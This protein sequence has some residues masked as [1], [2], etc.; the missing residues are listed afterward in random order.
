MEQNK[1]QVSALPNRLPTAVSDRLVYCQRTVTNGYTYIVFKLDGTLDVDR[2][3]R[4]VRLLVDAEPVLGSRF[5][6]GRFSPYW[7]RRDDL[8]DVEWVSVIEGTLVETMLDELADDRRDP[9]VDPVF[10]VLLFRG[11]TDQLTIEICNV[12]SDGS[13]GM[14]LFQRIGAI[15]EALAAHPDHVPKIGRFRE[16]GYGVVCRAMGWKGRWTILKNGVRTALRLNRAG[17]WK[18]EVPEEGPERTFRYTVVLEPDRVRRLSRYGRKHGASV[19]ILVLTAAYRALK[20][21][22]CPDETDPLPIMMPVSL[23][24]YFPGEFDD[25]PTHFVGA[26]FLL[27]QGGADV[28]FESTLE[29]FR[30]QFKAQR[31]TFLGMV[32][33]ALIVESLPPLNALFHCIPYSLIKSMVR[34]RTGRTRNS[35]GP[36]LMSFSC[37]DLPANSVRLG[38]HRVESV[39]VG[40]NVPRIAGVAGFGVMRIGDRLSITTMGFE[41]CLSP[42]RLKSVVDSLVEDL[43]GAESQETERVRGRGLEKEGGKECVPQREAA[44]PNGNGGKRKMNVEEKVREIILG[45]VD[46]SEDEIKA[47]SKLRSD[48]G[49]T[50]VEIVEVVAA[51]ENEFDIDI[52]DEEVQEIRTFGGIVEFVKGKVDGPN[53]DCFGPEVPGSLERIRGTEF[54]AQT[55]STCRDRAVTKVYQLGEMDVHALAGVSLKIEKGEF[56]ALVGPSGSGKSTLMNVLGCLDRPTSGSYLLDDVEVEKLNADA[57]AGIRNRKIG[58]VFQSFNLLSRTTAIENVELPMLYSRAVAIRDRRN[59]AKELLDLIVLRDGNILVDT[60][61]AEEAIKAIDHSARIDLDDEE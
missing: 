7:Q 47:D 53:G 8:D 49:A 46:V 22:F 14:Y 4:A 36:G 60:T 40:G 51:I 10:R 33:P 58:F 57:R 42:S 13:G 30:E 6:E 48:L 12:C 52:S 59:R 29:T 19:N 5:V 16:R 11:E 61:D 3:R 26:T 54:V 24:S 32:A 39:E 21:E 50:S 38:P 37:L 2:L 9:C 23:R 44:L 43:P 35:G 15:Y 27:G 17:R 45:I 28:P 41:H 34:R 55:V 31:K 1:Q 18:F 56:I 20:R 25:I